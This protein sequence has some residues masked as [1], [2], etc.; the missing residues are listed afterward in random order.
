MDL[1][2][3]AAAFVTRRQWTR[4][5]KL[6]GKPQEI[7]DQLLRNIIERNRA[8]RFG[9]DHGF[10]T[11]RS[12]ADYRQHVAIADYER[13]RPYVELLKNGESNVLTAEP[14]VMFTMTSGS[15]GEPKL[16]PVSVSARENHRQLTRLWYHRALLDHPNLFTGKLVGIVSPAIEGRTPGG[17]PFGA[18]SGLIYQSSPRWIQNAYAVP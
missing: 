10:G 6:T 9:R 3:K 7:Q 14:V 4:W 1:L 15:T 11:I 8:T 2:I 12:L 5:D 18:A 13:L 17:I 16:I